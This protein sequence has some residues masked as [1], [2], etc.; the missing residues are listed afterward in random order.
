MQKIFQNRANM[1]LLPPVK[2]HLLFKL[3]WSKQ[4]NMNSKSD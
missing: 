4:F 2:S 3:G 1:Q